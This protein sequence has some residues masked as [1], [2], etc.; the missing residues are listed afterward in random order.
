M[1]NKVISI[2]IAS[3]MLVSNQNFSVHALTDEN[4]DS[5]EVLDTETEQEDETE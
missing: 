5:E 4:V 1:K 2:I 3:F